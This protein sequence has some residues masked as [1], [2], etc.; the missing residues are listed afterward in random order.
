M[1]IKNGGDPACEHEWEFKFNAQHCKLCDRLEAY[2]L[3]YQSQFP[4]GESVLD[5]KSYSLYCQFKK[6]NYAQKIQS[7][8]GLR[9]ILSWWSL[10]LPSTLST[11]RELISFQE[12]TEHSGDM[13]FKLLMLYLENL[14]E[15][16]SDMEETSGSYSGNMSETIQTSMPYRTGYRRMIPPV[17]SLKHVVDTNGAVSASLVST[18]DVAVSNDAPDYVG[19]TNEVKNGSRIS[20]IFLRVECVLSTPAGGINNVYLAVVKNPSNQLTGVLR[21]DAVGVEAERKFVIHQE[22]LMLGNGVDQGSN[23]ART[24][25][26]GVVG[27]GR[28][29]RMGIKD[30]IQVL[31]SHRNGEATQ[32]TDFCVQCIYKEIS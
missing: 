10:E 22:M 13:T 14:E 7:P 4:F 18:S 26:K 29:K 23:I 27:L 1:F 9:R 11:E 21:P 12:L 6:S 31:L 15:R 30:K 24:L 20:A 19:T 3:D 5:L 28:Y 16:V 32:Q 8:E 17:Q 2:Y 25:F